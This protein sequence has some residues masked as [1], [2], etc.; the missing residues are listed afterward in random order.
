MQDWIVDADTKRMMGDL[1]LQLKPVVR[2]NIQDLA[3]TARYG[4]GGWTLQLFHQRGNDRAWELRLVKRF[5]HGTTGCTVGHC[6]SE[7][8]IL[9]AQSD[10]LAYYVA[11]FTPLLGPLTVEYGCWEREED[12]D[13]N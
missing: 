6:F 11:H 5:D 13:V 8:H 2:E 1:S 12:S 9:L 7:S 3:S 10:V 4:K